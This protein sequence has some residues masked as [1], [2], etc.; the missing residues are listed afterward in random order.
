MRTVLIRV[1]TLFFCSVMLCAS[2]AGCTGQ[3][4][5]TSGVSLSYSI[6]L[7][8]NQNM[9]R[10]MLQ[11]SDA[12]PG[13][14]VRWYLSGHSFDL[15]WIKN[16][17]E[18]QISAE[19][20]QDYVDIIPD[21]DSFSV[22]YIV[23]IGQKGKHGCAGYADRKRIT[24]SGAQL[25]LLPLYAF[26][27]EDSA[28]QSAVN[29]IE[30]RFEDEKNK[31]IS[32][33]SAIEK[34]SWNS[35]Y[36]FLQSSFTSGN[37]KSKTFDMKKG[38]LKVLAE[39][40]EQMQAAESVYQLY[41]AFGE[42]FGVVPQEYEVVFLNT[43]PGEE[44]IIGG[45]GA[46]TLAA[47]FD[48]SDQRDWEL[49]IHRLFHAFFETA[50]DSYTVHMPE[51]VWLYEGLASLY[52]LKMLPMVWEGTDYK[53]ELGRL[54]GQYLYLRLKY[55]NQ[56]A[57]TVD[58]DQT[59]SD[60]KKEFL[61]YIVAPI[62]IAK[63]GGETEV[64]LKAFLA[65]AGEKETEGFALSL[66]PGARKLSADDLIL[67]SEMSGGSVSLEELIIAEKA[68]VSWIYYDDP[69][70]WTIIPDPYDQA[71]ITAISEKLELHFSDKETET[72]IRWNFPAVYEGLMH[73][74]LVQYCFELL[75]ETPASQAAAQNIWLT[76]KNENLK[77]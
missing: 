31:E 6:S 64:F 34:L 77:K 65:S 12:K 3:V 49:L 44:Y 58:D 76:W 24:A 9:V 66:L 54:Y 37:F 59:A 27:T 21:S 46:Y 70:F 56:L 20:G 43:T 48:P 19:Q 8:A 45:A 55:P 47:T 68:V 7:G 71:D 17:T 23:S 30:V 2:T 42:L 5:N 4:K 29:T 57:V 33:P 18:Q 22:Y 52:E 38:K 61:H 36:Q 69:E 60:A 28:V 74:T 25:L 51:N 16:K 15:I 35:V 50:C 11:V 26:S 40:D 73:E 63:Q 75:N 53:T 14:K 10:V 72:W 67:W 39:T 62:I 41:Q 1:F 13:E 32:T